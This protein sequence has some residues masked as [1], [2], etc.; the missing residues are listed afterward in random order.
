MKGEKKNESEKGKRG[1]E[2]QRQR[3]TITAAAA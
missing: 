2:T 3:K 1:W